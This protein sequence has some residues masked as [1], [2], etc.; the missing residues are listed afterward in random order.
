MSNVYDLFWS[1]LTAIIG[2]T[3]PEVVGKCWQDVAVERED[4]VNNLNSADLSVPWCVVKLE[5]AP[6]SDWGIG[7]KKITMATIWYITSLQAAKASNVT[8]ATLVT[9]KIFDLQGALFTAQTI[10]TVLDDVAI[11]QNADNPVNVSL[12]DAKLLYQAA[13][14]TV[15]CVVAG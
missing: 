15:Q 5:I 4:W 14:L 12:L 7:P 1:G 11:D 8:A 9:D 13:S 2:A 10:G 3:W 6:T